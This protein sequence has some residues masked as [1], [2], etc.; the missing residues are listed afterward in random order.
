[1]QREKQSRWKI[2]VI[3]AVTVILT[4]A[5]LLGACG[6]KKDDTEKG[7]VYQKITAEQAKE[8]M[9][10]GDDIVIVDVRTEDEYAQ[11]HISGAILI[12]NETIGTEMPDAL[13]DTDQEILV[14]C[15]SGSRSAKASKK[16]IEAGYTN[17]Y[18]FGGI[19]DWP[20]DTVSE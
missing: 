17:V 6:K 12:P 4:A 10:S 1:M 5:A 2:M 3:T 8:R 20:Y 19:I 15:R 7:G 11:G 16:L 9:D 13:P 18:D 14:Y